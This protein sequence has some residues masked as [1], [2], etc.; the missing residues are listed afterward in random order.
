MGDD[1]L[2]GLS[3]AAEKTGLSREWLRKLYHRGDL[4]GAQKV[5]NSI[6]IPTRHVERLKLHPHR[7]RAGWPKGT[8]R[9][10]RPAADQPAP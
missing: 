8:P 4:P 1:A 9:P 10:R 7:P 3:E 2:I 5:G 6:G